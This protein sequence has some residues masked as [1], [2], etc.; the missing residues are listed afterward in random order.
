MGKNKP[1]DLA[2]PSASLLTPVNFLKLLFKLGLGRRGK[3][4]RSYFQLWM[5][6]ENCGMMVKPSL[7]S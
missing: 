5:L 2:V 4:K 7:N 3:S 6:S 1:E